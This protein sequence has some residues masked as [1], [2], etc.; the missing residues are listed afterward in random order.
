MAASRCRI[1][2]RTPAAPL[3][4]GDERGGRCRVV[5]RTGRTVGGVRQDVGARPVEEPVALARRH[6]DPGVPLVAE[7]GPLVGERRE[8]DAPATADVAD[9]VGV[10]HPGTVEEH[11]AEVRLAVHLA[12]RPDLDTRLAPSGSRS[13]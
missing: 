12:E 3:C 9:A 11:L 5:R 7:T 13:R 6:V 1:T 10:G 4:E 2:D 8:R